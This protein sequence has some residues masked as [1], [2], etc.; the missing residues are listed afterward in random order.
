ME[1]EPLAIEV[2]DAG[3]KLADGLD[4]EGM[5][6]ATGGARKWNLHVNGAE[7]SDAPR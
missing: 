3:A 7:D 4:V 6:F 2:E 1:S 5:L